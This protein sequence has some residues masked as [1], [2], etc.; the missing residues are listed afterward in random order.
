MATT[1]N[2]TLKMKRGT[3]ASIPTLK[4]GQLYLCS[5]THK[6]Y[7]GT[8]TGDNVLISDI[9]KLITNTNNIQTIN[10]NISNMTKKLSRYSFV[11]GNLT[12]STKIQIDMT[13]TIDGNIATLNGSTLSIKE[14][15]YYSFSCYLPIQIGETGKFVEFAMVNVNNDFIFSASKQH[16]SNADYLTLNFAYTGLL[17]AGDTVAFTISHNGTSAVVGSGMIDICKL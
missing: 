12:G 15:G 7:K 5:D 3:E 2:A 14:T 9:N 6:V 10:T 1:V 13:N 4:D 8:S 16:T 11:S 17:N